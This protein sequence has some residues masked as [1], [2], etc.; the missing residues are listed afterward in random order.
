VNPNSKGGQK[1]QLRWLALFGRVFMNFQNLASFHGTTIRSLELAGPLI[2]KEWRKEARKTRTLEKMLKSS[3]V[4]NKKKFLEGVLQTTADRAARVSRQT[5]ESAALV[6]AHTVL[7]DALSEC[8]QVCF[9]AEPSDWHRC[10]QKRTIDL[11]AL[12]RRSTNQVFDQYAGEFVDQLTRESMVKRLRF[13]NQICVP[14]LQGAKIPTASVGVDALQGFDEVRQRV[15]HGNNPT[16]AI[17]RVVEQIQ[18]AKSSG[19][20]VLQL[21]GEAHC[22]LKEEPSLDNPRIALKLIANFKREFPE[23]FGFLEEQA[24][25][26]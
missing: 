14:R 3:P 11:A 21:V 9:I 15:I 20:A 4:R 1:A 23:F 18:F 6:I 8:C 22:F 19:F 25:V 5:V 7:D 16:K 24:G 17:P 12:K 13:L 10:V 26:M 2:K